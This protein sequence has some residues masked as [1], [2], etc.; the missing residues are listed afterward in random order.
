MRCDEAL[1][2]LSESGAGGIRGLRARLH[3]VF[4]PGCRELLERER[5]AMA[6][7]AAYNPFPAPKDFADGI[8]ARI[9][10][11]AELDP[12]SRNPV[13]MSGWVGAGLLILIGMPLLQFSASHLWLRGQLGRALEVPLF[14]AMGVIV[15]A[16]MALFI[17][18]HLDDFMD[19]FGLRK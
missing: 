19:R 15:T 4:C 8:M 1:R 11:S 9:R 2:I 7:L 3:L 6:A 12:A 5:E 17:G 16:Y 10:Y 13:P 14:I 18:T